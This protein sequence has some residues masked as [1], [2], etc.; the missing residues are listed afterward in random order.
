[1]PKGDPSFLWEGHGVNEMDIQIRRARPED[2][3]EVARLFHE[4][5]HRINAADYTPAQLQA[6]SPEIRP[7]A[8]WR[9]RFRKHKVLVAITQDRL[10]GFAELDANG[11]IESFFI[12]HRLQHQGVGRQLMQALFQL[13]RTL[14]LHRLSA[15]VSIT[16]KAFFQRMG[17][18]VV[19]RTKRYY[20]N[21]VFRQYQMVRLLRP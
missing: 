15:D 4:T 17:F 11:Y 13:A 18:R 21:Q 6:W 10:A 9:K 2:A 8:F 7:E 5:V 16:A 19:R 3:A 20:R 14:G 12:H 1:M